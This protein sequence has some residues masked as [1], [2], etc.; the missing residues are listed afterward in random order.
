MPPSPPSAGT[1]AEVAAG[2]ATTSPLSSGAGVRPA[3]Q[4][5]LLAATPAANA[6]LG[7]PAA[8]AAPPS[9][10]CAARR[11]QRAGR[12]KFVRGLACFSPYLLII[13]APCRDKA[14][15]SKHFQ[16]HISGFKNW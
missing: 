7:T 15:T 11:I 4:D 13:P 5:S 8:S 14:R 6:S 12:G 3:L 2:L 1:A 16:E 10:G 9:E